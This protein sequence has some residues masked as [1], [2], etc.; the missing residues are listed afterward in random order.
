MS[1]L[2]E[3]A[4]LLGISGGMIHLSVGIKDAEELIVGLQNA[5]A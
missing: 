2:A 3:I 1:P 5:L 4:R